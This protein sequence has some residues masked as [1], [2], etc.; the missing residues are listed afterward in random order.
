MSERTVERRFA[1]WRA[2]RMEARRRERVSVW[3][4][5]VLR[6]RVRAF[7]FRAEAV[8]RDSESRRRVSWEMRF[9]RFFLAGGCQ[10]WGFEGGG[11]EGGIDVEKGKSYFFEK[12]LDLG[13]GFCFFFAGFWGD[14]RGGGEARVGVEEGIG[15]G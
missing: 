14:V 1:R 15:L 7:C 8:R 4:A 6:W 2:V 3:S 12:V 13:F 11:K 10:L 9:S 5:R